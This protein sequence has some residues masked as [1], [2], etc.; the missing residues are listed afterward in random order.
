LVSLVCAACGDA[1]SVDTGTISL[2]GSGVSGSKAGAA[3][4]SGSGGTTVPVA[5]RAGGN[6]V[7]AG[8]GAGVAGST[9][10]IPG[11]T[12]SPGAA[13]KNGAIS[14]SG[15]AGYRAPGGAGTPAANSASGETGRL[16][17]ITAAHNAVRARP[18][19][20][21]NPAPNP[22][23]PP[24]TWSTDLAA[25]AQA[26][27]DKLAQGDC[28]LVHSMAPGLGE[29]LA[30]YGGQKATATQAVEGWAA[31]EQCYTFGTFMRDDVCDMTCTDKQFSNGCGHYTQLVWRNTSQVGCGVATCTAKLRGLEQEIWVCNYKAPG[32]YISQKAY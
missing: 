11:G 13:G 31:E 14:G 29:N 15:A 12:T 30:Y 8:A 28:Q 21:N 6:A 23:L 26:Y 10:N 16:I 2:A 17:G 24:L 18:R 7:S 20:V 4:I 22:A 3:A 19:L 27:A 25:T 1:A 5:G 9:G 32:N